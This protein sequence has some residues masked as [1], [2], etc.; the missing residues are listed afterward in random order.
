MLSKLRFISKLKL[1]K[2]ALFYLFHCESQNFKQFNHY[3]N[4]YFSHSERDH[5]EN[6]EAAKETFEIFEKVKKC[7]I[8]V[9]DSFDG[10]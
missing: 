6:L 10:L 3:L 8:T 7:I 4:Q 2:S 5:S 9:A 1:T